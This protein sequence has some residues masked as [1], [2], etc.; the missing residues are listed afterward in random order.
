MW[1]PFL[2]GVAQGVTLFL[3]EVVSASQSHARRT[4]PARDPNAD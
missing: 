1:L 2:A 3:M 4:S